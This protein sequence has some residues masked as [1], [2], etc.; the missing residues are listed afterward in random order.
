M[1]KMSNYL[2]NALCDHIFRNI[3]YTSPTT[4]YIALYKSDPTD[5]DTGIEV[6]GGSYA[7]QPVTFNA[8]SDGTVTNSVDI[9]FPVATADWGTITHVGLRDASVAG[10]L[11]FYGPLTVSKTISAGDQFRILAGNL[12]VTLS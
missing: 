8:P 1:S 12:S 4:V 7:R 2:E 3:S 10:N 9:S 11:L 5:A 6:E